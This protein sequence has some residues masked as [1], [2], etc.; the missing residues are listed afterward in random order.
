[1][2]DIIVCY[3]LTVRNEGNRIVQFAYG[4]TNID[5]IKIEK[6]TFHLVTQTDNEFSTRYRWTKNDLKQNGILWQHDSMDQ[7]QNDFMD[8][9][10]K[11]KK[12]QN[13]SHQ[14]QTLRLEYL[15]LKSYRSHFKRK[16]IMEIEQSYHI[17]RIIQQIKKKKYYIGRKNV[18]LNPFY[19]IKQ[20]QQLLEFIR[21]NCHTEQ[22]PFTELNKYNLCETRAWI[23]S[24]LASKKI[25]CTDKLHRLQY[26]D[27]LTKIKQKFHE[28][29]IDPGTSVGILGT[30]SIGEPCT[31]LSVSYDTLVKVF[32]QNKQRKV[33]IGKMIDKYM[34]KYKDSV[35]S[36]NT[37]INNNKVQT[38]RL[39]EKK[40]KINTGPK[41]K[42]VP[43]S[44][45]NCEKQL[46]LPDNIHIDENKEK[47]TTSDILVVPKKWEIFVPGIDCKRNT[48]RICRVTELSRHPPNGRLVKI[49]TKSKK[50]IIATCAH[51]FITKRKNKLIKIRGDALTTNDMLPNIERY[52]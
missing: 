28:N 12:L 8:E 39:F 15:K 40:M 5:T 44:K 3:D 11:V 9:N 26:D 34:T 4:R 43:L 2:E 21:L 38:G 36:S 25:I 51:S 48:V 29:L 42:G 37:I 1:M 17:N 10:I 47:K 18:K 20:N 30:Q 50:V 16:G 19:I 14:I 13:Y 33:K 23:L 46:F 52:L 45:K 41:K 32:I 24:C 31:Q 22:F 7:R 35:V 49:T 6:K 27:I